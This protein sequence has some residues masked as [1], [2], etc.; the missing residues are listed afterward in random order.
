VAGAG[1]VNGDGFA[2]IIVGAPYE[3]HHG[4]AGEG[5]ALV[6]YGSM[7]GPS[8]YP[9]WVTRGGQFA[10]RYGASVAHAGDVNGDG[11]ADVLVGAPTYDHRQVDAGRAVLYFGSRYGLNTSP[12]WSVRGNQAGAQLG[13]SVASAGDVNGDGFSDVIIGAPRRDDAHAD[14]GAAYVYHGSPSGLDTAPAFTAH[15]GQAHARFAHSVASAGDVNGDT[16][17]DIVVGAPLGEVSGPADTGIVFVWHGGPSGVGTVGNWSN[18]DWLGVGERSGF[19]YGRS[20][21]CAGDVNGDGFSDL[22]IGVPSYFG[23]NCTGVGRVYCLPGSRDGIVCPRWTVGHYGAEANDGVPILAP[24]PGAGDI[25][26]DA[27]VN[28][29]D[30]QVLASVLRDPRRASAAEARAADI[31]LDGDIDSADAEDL[32]SILLSH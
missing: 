8:P 20:V 22:L 4:P 9:D 17:S 10:A 18:V 14:E 13:T 31:N 27:R 12:A 19:S 7:S 23:H 29:R 28:G 25:N 11:F 2:D 15:G 26:G 24:P 6:F 16:Y 5:R 3:S 1:D 32:I 21:G 30:I